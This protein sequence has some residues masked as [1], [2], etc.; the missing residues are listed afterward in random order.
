M[1]HYSQ[2]LGR[3]A[4]DVLW[5]EIL[6]SLPLE[7]WSHLGLAFSVTLEKHKTPPSQSNSVQEASLLSY[8]RLHAYG[9]SK[10]KKKNVKKFAST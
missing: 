10:K 8:P 1:E 7:R 6:A 5:D 2:L 3:L 4:G 9:Q